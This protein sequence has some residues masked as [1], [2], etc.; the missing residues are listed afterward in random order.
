M[1]KEGPSSQNPGSATVDYAHK[2]TLDGQQYVHDGDA[3][4]NHCIQYTG[5]GWTDH[6]Q[7]TVMSPRR[8]I[9]ADVG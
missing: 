9:L 2:T 3:I 7:A 4:M 6:Q 1:G 8:E 5:V